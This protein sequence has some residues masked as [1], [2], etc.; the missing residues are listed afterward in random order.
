MGR[1]IPNGKH[2]GG[3]VDNVYDAGVGGS[4]NYEYGD[5]QYC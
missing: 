1:R 5:L 2:G 3:R 4:A